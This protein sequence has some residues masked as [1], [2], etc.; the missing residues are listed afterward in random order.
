MS[1]RDARNRINLAMGVIVPWQIQS[2]KPRFCHEHA[3]VSIRGFCAPFQSRGWR[4]KRTGSE[5]RINLALTSSGLQRTRTRIKIAFRSKTL[6]KFFVFCARL[7][8][9]TRFTELNSF[10]IATNL[11]SNLGLAT[12]P[13][14]PNLSGSRSNR[15]S[16]M[17]TYIPFRACRCDVPDTPRFC[18]IYTP[19]TRPD[20]PRYSEKRGLS[21][22]FSR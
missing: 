22:K 20:K 15:S 8:I 12:Q 21:G 4:G 5:N 10:Q 18:Y 17:L 13:P 7:L 6:A 14:T 3:W 11:A 1:A 2:D 16:L 9:I 19:R